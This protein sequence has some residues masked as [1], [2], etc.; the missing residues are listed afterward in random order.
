M[1]FLLYLPND[2]TKLKLIYLFFKKFYSIK[3]IKLEKK[4]KNLDIKINSKLD[5]I[6]VNS[7]LL[8]KK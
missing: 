8:L 5:I 4:R 6:L 7:R 1:I 3:K 2:S